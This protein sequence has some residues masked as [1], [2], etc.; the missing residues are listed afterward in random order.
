MCGYICVSGHFFSPNKFSWDQHWWPIIKVYRKWKAFIS[1]IYISNRGHLY[2]QTVN[3][4][5]DHILI[6]QS[7]RS[8][9]HA[10]ECWI[11]TP[12]VGSLG[13]QLCR[14]FLNFICFIDVITFN[15]TSFQLLLMISDKGYFFYAS[16]CQSVSLEAKNDTSPRS[17]LCLRSRAGSCFSFGCLSAS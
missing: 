3:G 7:H 11:C 5:N 17:C 14:F 16:I 13:F 2:C 9:P 6:L 8:N 15:L 4:A 12:C 10:L 1:D